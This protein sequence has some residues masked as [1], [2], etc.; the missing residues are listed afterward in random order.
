VTDTICVVL[1]TL[2]LRAASPHPARAT[3]DRMAEAVSVN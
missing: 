1:T 2:P 3:S